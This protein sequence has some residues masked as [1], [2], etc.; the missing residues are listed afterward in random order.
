MLFVEEAGEAGGGFAAADVFAEFGPEEF[1]AGVGEVGSLFGEDAGGGAF[2]GFVLGE[3]VVDGADLG[4][5][6]QSGHP[7]IP[8][9]MHIKGDKH[10]GRI[11]LFRA[12][13]RTRIHI[14]L[15][16]S[17]IFQIRQL[18]QIHLCSYYLRGNL[19]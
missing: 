8:R 5:V 17:H 13:K 2:G 10:A 7:A 4:V 6:H 11:R 12:H 16:E 18:N 9:L 3:V 15:P 14:F 19:H 1:V